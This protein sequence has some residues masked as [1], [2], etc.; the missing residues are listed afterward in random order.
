MTYKSLYPSKYLSLLFNEIQLFG[1]GQ[2]PGLMPS[3]RNAKMTYVYI[4]PIL[5][6]EQNPQ[7]GVTEFI[8]IFSNEVQKEIV[9]YL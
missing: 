6:I 3:A 5:T 9:T 7:S 8:N 4:V 2:V 1:L